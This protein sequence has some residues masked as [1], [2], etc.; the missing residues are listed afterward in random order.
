MFITGGHTARRLWRQSVRNFGGKER[1]IVQRLKSVTTIEKITKSMKMVASSK[2]NQD[3]KRLRAGENYGRNAVDHIFKADLYMQRKMPAEVAEPRELLIPITSDKGLCGSIN[4]G[5]ARMLRGY[6][7]SETNRFGIYSLGEKGSNALRRPFA[8]IYKG[9]ATD[10]TYPINYSLS[11]ALAD[12]IG[13]MAD[14]YDKI[15]LVHN[16]FVNAVTFKIHRIEL[17]TK[18]RF[19]ECMKFQR[20]YEMEKPDATTAVPA[21][22]EL[23]ISSNLYYAQ[24]QNAACEQSSRMVAMDN[25]SKNAG[26]MVEK[27]TLEFNKARQQSITMELCE[28]ISGAE[29]L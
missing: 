9:G 26:E 21:I 19:A 27:L 7:G 24:L 1:V 25:A 2:M 23:Y 28:I 22:Y 14:D 11:L 3:I 4:S 8:S 29:A 13:R 20:L 6:I 16:K 18:K 5:L 12:K 17:M 10:L 15:V